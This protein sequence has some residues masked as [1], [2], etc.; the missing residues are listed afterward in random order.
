MIR[1]REDALPHPSDDDVCRARERKNCERVRQ[2]GSRIKE[3][4]FCA[5]GTGVIRLYSSC[6]RTSYRNCT[7]IRTTAIASGAT[8]DRL[9]RKD[10][11]TPHY[12]S[13]DG[14]FASHEDQKEVRELHRTL[15]Q[16][17]PGPG[18]VRIRR[19][20]ALYQNWEWTISVGHLRV[21]ASDS[22]RR[23]ISAAG[24]RSRHILQIRSADLR[25]TPTQLP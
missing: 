21:F 3:M 12:Y 6:H 2:S 25:G 19:N 18:A 17:I 8:V 24:I 7:C 5:K 14:P 1:H 9:L 13:D 10:E 11:S 23:K 22:T 15:Q 20:S 16:P 4:E